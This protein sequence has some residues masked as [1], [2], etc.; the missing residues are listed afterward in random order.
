MPR[1]ANINRREPG[2]ERRGRVVRTPA[3][4]T[5]GPGFKTCKWRPAI[6]TEVFRGFPCSL[7]AEVGKSAYLK[8]GHDY[9]LVHTIL[10][11]IFCS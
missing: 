3:S 4:Y 10:E 5:A 6:L 2:T 9:S 1:S 7:L 11:L 8:L